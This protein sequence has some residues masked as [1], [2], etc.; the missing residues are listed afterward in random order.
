MIENSKMRQVGTVV[1]V[2]CTT[3]AALVI[4]IVLLN[5]VREVLCTPIYPFKDLNRAGIGNSGQGN[6]SGG[7]HGGMV[8]AVDGERLY[9][10][11]CVACHQAEGMGKVGFAP[12]IR[13]HDF[14]ALASDDY[15]RNSI[16]AGRPGTAMTS[17][18]F[19]KPHEIDNLVA[20]LRVGEK[21]SLSTLT[22]A[23]PK[24]KHPGDAV[25]GKPLYN[26]YCA[27]CHGV[28][29]TGYAE[30]GPGPG[31]GN[32]GFL[33]VASDDFI[34]QTIKH[35]R[36]G[37]AMRPFIG[38]RGL[39]GLDES[40]VGDIIAYL[41]VMGRE[42]AKKPAV[43]TI[44]AGDAKSG[45]MH[46]TANCASCHQA[47]GSGLPGFAPSIRN[48][49][50]LAIASDEFIKN[51]IKKGRPGTSMVMRPDLDDQTVTDII[52][53]LRD[54]PEVGESNIKVDPTIDYASLGDSARGLEIFNIYCAS[55]HGESG[56]GYV[57]GGP[58]SGIG[59]KG[60]L[61]E[62]SD[63][64]IFQTLKL[65]RAGTPMRAFI[66]ARGLANLKDEDAYDI[67]AYLRSLNK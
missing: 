21:G 11:Y 23:D 43:T 18:S 16:V 44:K 14:L 49:D 52:A 63:D 8:S 46:F 38:A 48:A 53:F 26:T 17:W 58:G 9:N 56:K 15:L 19:L 3:V 10:T 32:A 55:C 27:S 33:A 62:A 7:G 51:T 6:Q 1:L 54:V 20:Y 4:T 65:G 35:G 41:R 66:G 50:F 31:I 28:N 39:A 30:G 22:T 59:L 25:S 47:D 5:S 13:N 67:I 64:Y 24:I 37:T 29:G 40:E 2:A 45:E 61:D 12:Y 34:F 60:F 42:I 57:A 36:A